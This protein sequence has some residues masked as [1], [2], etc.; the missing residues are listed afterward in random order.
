MMQPKKNNLIG[1]SGQLGVGMSTVPLFGGSMSSSNINNNNGVSGGN[2]VLQSI[3]ERR[4]SS[5]V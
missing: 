2:L 4:A 1:G 5:Q 3:D